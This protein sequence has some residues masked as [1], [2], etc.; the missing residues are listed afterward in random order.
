M[1]DLAAALNTIASR[2][3]TDPAQL[4]E[5][6][7]VVVAR[8]LERVAGNQHSRAPAQI[9][10]ITRAILAELHSVARGAMEDGL[11][12]RAPTQGTGD[13]GDSSEQQ[14]RRRYMQ[15]QRQR[16]AKRPVRS[17][18]AADTGADGL[19]DA[20]AAKRAKLLDDALIAAATGE[21]FDSRVPYDIAY[22]ISTMLDTA[23]LAAWA[24]VA[25]FRRIDT[26]LARRAQLKR[27][28]VAGA[29]LNWVDAEGDQSDAQV[30]AG[31][32]TAARL[33]ALCRVCHETDMINTMARF[34]EMRNTDQLV[35]YFRDENAWIALL[36]VWMTSNGETPLLLE[37]KRVLTAARTTRR[38][39][40]QSFFT[41]AQ[42]GVPS[43]YTD[44]VTSATV[45][46]DRD[47]MDLFIALSETA[48]SDAP[49]PVISTKRGDAMHYALDASHPEHAWKPATGYFQ[50]YSAYAFIEPAD[51]ARFAR[52]DARI[53]AFLR[54]MLRYVP[55]AADIDFTLAAVPAEAAQ[56]SLRSDSRKLLGLA[57]APEKRS[58]LNLDVRFFVDACS[59][60]IDEEITEAALYLDSVIRRYMYAINQ[61]LLRIGA[62]EYVH[63][64]D[65]DDDVDNATALA[66]A[67]RRW[68]EVELEH[69]KTP[70]VGSMPGEFNVGAIQRAVR[71]ETVLP[72]FLVAFDV[73]P[74]LFGT[75]TDVAL[76][77]ARALAPN[78]IEALKTD[79]AAMAVNPETSVFAANHMRF[80]MRNYSLEAA[81]APANVAYDAASMPNV[82]ASSGAA[83]D[84]RLIDDTITRM[85][86]TGL[87]YEAAARRV[88]A[89]LCVAHSSRRQVT[90]R[91]RTLEQKFSDAVIT[92]DRLPQ[93]TLGNI[94]V[95]SL[96]ATLNVHP[97]A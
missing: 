95:I 25:N 64:Y 92:S 1:A 80:L 53:W 39:A 82:R 37:L 86:Q 23:S 71:S 27:P 33:E 51:A 22:Y 72:K 66:A 75:K 11:P 56:V 13:K 18:D 76:Y 88:A 20:P 61:Y 3:A 24:H 55:D 43:A 90:D 17:D 58:A 28:F 97:V 69:A 48:Q 15:T 46:I 59:L 84:P 36:Q 19:G 40:R 10:L 54:L 62:M 7:A 50:Q 70:I 45:V 52:A 2:Y 34:M 96:Y 60:Q 26:Q 16:D 89:K 32:A 30:K 6:A 47:D 85:R 35:A 41:R 63:V 5:L 65:D 12:Q 73:S 29:P 87:S 94:F 78:E 83:F 38:P 67:A 14:P 8:H 9:L 31:E 93:T 49:T 4:S 91:T 57:C 44:T 81:D 77:M 42:A 74:V 68:I 21:D 79:L